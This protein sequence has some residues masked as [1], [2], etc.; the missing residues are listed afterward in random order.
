MLWASICMGRR[1]RCSE[2][3]QALSVTL[4]CTAFLLSGDIS[5]RVPRTDGYSGAH[6]LLLGA[7]LMMLYLAVDGLTSTW[8]DQLFK[9][10]SME[11]SDQVLFTTA[12]SALFSFVAGG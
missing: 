11:I 7:S 6:A 8:Q 10:Y 1:Y 2:F 12:F 5:S 4:G 3:T 9:T